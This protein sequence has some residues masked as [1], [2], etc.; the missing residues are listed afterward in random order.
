[1]DILDIF[2]WIPQKELSIEQIEKIVRDIEN[3]FF[4]EGYNVE[5]KLHS[6]VNSYV[7]DK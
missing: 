5:H 7:I 4:H 1:M 6:D 3:G 2:S